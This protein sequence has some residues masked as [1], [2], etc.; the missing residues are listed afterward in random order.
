MRTRRLF[1]RN[2]AFS[3]TEADLTGLFQPYGAPEQ[4]SIFLFSADPR[5]AGVHGMESLYRDIGLLRGMLIF[6]KSRVEIYSDLK[7]FIAF[8]PN[9]RY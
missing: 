2:L 7:N 9:T 1:L 3:C 6:G 4:V 5:L 8:F